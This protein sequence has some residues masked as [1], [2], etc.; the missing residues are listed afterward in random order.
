MK[1]GLLPKEAQL[2]QSD[3]R[4]VKDLQYFQDFDGPF[5]HVE[6]VDR[7][8]ANDK[9]AA[10]TQRKVLYQQIR[11]DRDTCLSLPK[12]S[13]IFRFMKKHQCLETSVY[14]NNLKTYSTKQIRSNMRRF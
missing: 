13:E 10:E 7:F 14:A 2:L 9:I 8:L 6:D 1:Q 11:F 12:S 5:S 3:Q 4:R